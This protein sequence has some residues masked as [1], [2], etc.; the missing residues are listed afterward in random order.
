MMR[1]AGLRGLAILVSLVACARTGAAFGGEPGR[2]AGASTAH[3]AD[4]G[5]SADGGTRAAADAPATEQARALVERFCAQEFAS[6]QRF[7]TAAPS[8]ERKKQMLANDEW[9]WLPFSGPGD[10]WVVVTSWKVRSLELAGDKGTALVRYE[11]LMQSSDGRSIQSVASP[12]E[13]VRLTL[14]RQDGRWWV[15]DPG[16]VHVGLD[17]LIN[18]YRQEL[19]PYEAQWEKSPHPNQKAVRDSIRS[20]LDQL[21]KLRTRGTPPR[22]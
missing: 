16:A 2:D 3:V 20:V 10:A 12:S 15:I 19:A 8:E 21:E 9:E 5:V 4:A 17:G 14:Q 1:E 6:G 7:D 11:R 18:A 22:P 13:E